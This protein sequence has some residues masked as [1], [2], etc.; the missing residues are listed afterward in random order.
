MEVIVLY[1]DPASITFKYTRDDSVQPNG[2]TVHVDNLCTDPNLLAA[3]HAADADPGPRYIFFGDHGF[4]Y[5]LPNLPAGQV[6]GTAR[7]GELRVAIVDTGA[8]MDPRSC[9][10]WWQIRPGHSCP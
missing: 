5:N 4:H 2:Y 3:Y 10:E 6:F 1:A 8:F 7:S 9:G